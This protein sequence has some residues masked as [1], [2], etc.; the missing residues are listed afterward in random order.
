[1]TKPT[2]LVDDWMWF[3]SDM[4]VSSD[5]L[6]GKHADCPLCNHVNAFRTNIRKK[7]GVYV[8]KHCTSSSYA[9]PLDFIKRFMGFSDYFEASN[10]IR[11][12]KQH[13]YSTAVRPQTLVQPVREQDFDFDK[14]VRKRAWIW[15]KLARPV[16]EGDPVW[17]YLKGRIP[18]LNEI[19]KN[20]RFM[21]DAQYWDKETR[22]MTGIHPA[23]LVRG[24]D[25]E[26]RCVQLHTTYLTA[27]GQKADV[28]NVKKIKT[29]IGASSFSYPLS[30]L[31][32]GDELALTEGLETG[33]AVEARFGY[34]VR[35]CH[36]NTVLANFELP[37]D[38]VSRIRKLHIFADNDG[39]RVKADGV[40][41]NPGVSKA[42][43]LAERMRDIRGAEGKRIKV[44]IHYKSSIGDFAD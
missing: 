6:T 31:D 28:P 41:W 25:K 3:Y 40:R 20:I 42:R 23:M 16:T 14:E 29:S 1:M 11:E 39:W 4:G 22:S 5:A 27:A 8:C 36:S 21:P 10:F 13:G 34:P 19:P 32:Q 24:F 30:E 44:L 2:D 38:I 7:P 15:E 33:L 12:K 26:G 37:V 9:T 18:N 35:A 43:E 17:N